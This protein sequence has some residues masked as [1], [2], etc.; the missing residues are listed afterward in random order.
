MEE[1]GGCLGGLADVRFHVIEVDVLVGVHPEDLLV[2]RLAFVELP[3]QLGRAVG[4]GLSVDDQWRGGPRRPAAPRASKV[5]R[6][7]SDPLVTSLRQY[8]AAD[9]AVP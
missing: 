3:R 6:E 9:R 7:W 4:V 2:A 1:V 5:I 8:G